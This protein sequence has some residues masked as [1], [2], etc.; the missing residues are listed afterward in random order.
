MPI[1]G[2]VSYSYFKEN[3]FVFKAAKIPDK[4]MDSVEAL[5]PSPY[6]EFN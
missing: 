1:C 2:T 5:A 4:K 6:Q 3:D